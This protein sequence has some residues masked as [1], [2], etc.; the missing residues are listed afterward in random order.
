MRGQIALWAVLVALG[1]A[2]GWKV[3]GWRLEA[4]IE[5]L[6]GQYAT[7][8]GQAQENARLKEQKMQ[9]SANK[10]RREKDAQID[11]ISRRLASALNGLRDRPSI[12]TRPEPSDTGDR[13]P[14]QGCSGAELYRESAE[15]I[16]REAARADTIREGYKQCLDQYNSVRRILNP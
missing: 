4:R 6:R 11:N 12:A 7:A 16:V 14:A 2:L 5:A 10:L 15:D 8:L 1:I 3:N 9:D 13:P